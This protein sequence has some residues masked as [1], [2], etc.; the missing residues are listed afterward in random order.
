MTATERDR[1]FEIFYYRNAKQPNE[2]VERFINHYE[3]NGWCRNG[4]SRPVR[5]KYAL[6]K[7]W[8]FEDT[9]PRYDTRTMNVLTKFE[10]AC[11]EI[12]DVWLSKQ[13]NTYLVG[14]DEYNGK[15]RILLTDKAAIEAIEA[16]KHI[17]AK[18]LQCE[19]S[20]GVKRK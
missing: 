14:I 16:H 20:Y 4:S 1:F 11:I 2:E 10:A 6:A 5:N 18:H 3:A 15:I 12:G 13:L 8:K 7:S 9:T 19:W 17:I